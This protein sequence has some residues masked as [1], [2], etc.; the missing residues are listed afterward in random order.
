MGETTLRTVL[1]PAA[2]LIALSA[3][4]GGGGV[5]PSPVATTP[6]VATSGPVTFSETPGLVCCPS[7][8]TISVQ[9]NGVATKTITGSPA[10]T[11]Q[12]TPALT[13]QV[14]SDVQKAW[15]LNALQSVPIVPDSGALTIEW[16]GQTS[17]DILGATA[18]IESALNTDFSNVNAAFGQ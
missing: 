4:G 8:F 13:S 11:M 18:G 9:S 16:S 5:T 17:P 3:C 7:A 2:A 10:V 6:P 15:P 12:L 14:F 1:A